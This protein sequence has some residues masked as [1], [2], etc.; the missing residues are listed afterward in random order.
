MTEINDNLAVGMCAAAGETAEHSP[1]PKGRAIKKRKV[2]SIILHIFVYAFLLFMAFICLAPFWLLLVNSSRSSVEIQSG[3]SFWFGSSLADNYETLTSM[4]FSVWRG[5]FNSLVIAFAS[6]ALSVFFSAAT[7]YGFTG[8]HFKGKRA[9][10]GVVMAILMVP[11]QLGIIGFYQ[12]CSKMNILDSYVPLIIPAIAT[13]SC[14][15]FMKQY[16][17]ANFPFEI[18]DAARIDGSSEIR[19]FLCIVLPLMTPAIATMGIMG[20]IGSW[21]NYMGPLMILT[22]TEKFTLPVLVDMLKSDIYSSQYGATYLGL[23]MSV[24]PLLVIY[25]C[26][27]KY[28]IRGVAIGGLKE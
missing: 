8:Y 28:I 16:L 13:A 1:A 25:L 17:E 23:M 21:N 3:M 11:S 7:A 19:S 26:L 9:L 24:L 12:M 22:S 20:I 27:S 6:A 14:V 15:F 5:F 2:I 10:F 18:I 4:G